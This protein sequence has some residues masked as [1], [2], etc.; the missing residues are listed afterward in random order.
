MLFG[1]GVACSSAREERKRE[2]ERSLSVLQYVPDGDVILFLE[3]H[4]H[5]LRICRTP[6]TAHRL[7]TGYFVIKC[8]WKQHESN[9]TEKQCQLLCCCTWKDL[10]SESSLCSDDILA[11]VKRPHTGGG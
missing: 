10:I 5:K 8:N 6:T 3:T 9:H 7:H 11:S 4:I 2:R 1:E